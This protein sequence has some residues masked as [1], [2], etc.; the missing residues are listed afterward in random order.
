MKQGKSIVELAKELERV[1]VA[2]KDFVVPTEKLVAKVVEAEKP[3]LA[4]TFQN[5]KEHSFGLNSWSSSQ[6]AGY[7]D[8][9]KNYFDRIADENP[10]LAAENVNHGLERIA[11]AARKEAKNE[12][13]LVRTIDGHVRGLMSSRYRILDAHDMLETVF[14]VIQSKGMEVVSSEVTE[15]RLFIKALSPKLTAEVKKGDVVQYGLL[16]STSD[17]GAGS[18]RVEPFLFRLVCLNGMISNTAI[19][20]FH[21]GRNQAED[22]IRELLSDKTR[23]LEDAA[24]WASVR[25]VTLS[26]MKPENFEAQV[27]RLRVAANLEIK[28]F[29]LPRVVELTM[30]ATGLTGEGKKNSILAALA[31]G[32]EG[33]G[34]TQWGL[35][36][37]ITRAA[38]DDAVTYEDSIEMERAAG[39]ILE[40]PKAQWSTIAAVG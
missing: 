16:I 25:D 27:D 19:R 38:Q 32:N 7:T 8:I 18:V 17:V 28:N 37:S 15:R 24:F 5:G 1:K 2:A 40:L 13:R 29:D 39:Q 23:D 35:I 26:S 31:S 20:K 3:K 6:L 33:A 10:A 11:K 4:L 14:P 30:R 36:N 12:S 21:V 9:P 34:L 22:D